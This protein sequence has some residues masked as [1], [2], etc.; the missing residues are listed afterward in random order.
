MRTLI[1]IS[2]TAAMLLSGAIWS[3]ESDPARQLTEQW[4]TEQAQRAEREQRL[5]EL[6]SVMAEEMEA[7]HQTDDREKHRQLMATHRNH[8][9]EA[10]DLMRDM[11]GAH[12][13]DLVTEH[14]APHHATHHASG[15]A[16]MGSGG[17]MMMSRP[18]AHMSDATRLGDLETRVDMMQLMME[19]MLTEQAGN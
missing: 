15:M 2:T 1:V 9:Y 14:L 8:M 4:Q 12:M 10:M 13:R 3:Q 6:M 19:S 16:G 18:R 7:L 5:N 11:G 17:H